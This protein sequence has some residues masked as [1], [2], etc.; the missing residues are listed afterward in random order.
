MNPFKFKP[1]T[2]TFLKPVNQ[3][4]SYHSQL[5]YLAGNI[6]SQFVHDL[7]LNN[8][9]DTQFHHIVKSIGCSSHDKGLIL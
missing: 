1:G 5:G 7:V 9:R 3:H 2:D 6:S 4:D 8:Q